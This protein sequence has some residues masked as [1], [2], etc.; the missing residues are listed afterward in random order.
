MTFSCNV[1]TDQGVEV[2]PKRFEAVKNW[3]RPLTTIHIRSFLG[4][5]NYY[6]IFVEGFSTIA[7]PLTALTKK[8]VKFEWSEKCEK[9]F[10][11]LKD[12][13]TSAQF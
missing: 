1:V 8:K 4:L 13:L 7:A 6:R 11:D 10:Q 12:R 9:S 3:S 5:D 2:D